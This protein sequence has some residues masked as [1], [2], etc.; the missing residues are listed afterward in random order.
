[1]LIKFVQNSAFNEHFVSKNFDSAS[2]NV[3]NAT[4]ASAA[5]RRASARSRST[6]VIASLRAAYKRKDGVLPIMSC[7]LLTMSCHPQL[8]FVCLVYRRF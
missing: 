4:Y 1:M 2:P 5:S 8:N 6:S 3:T 7:A